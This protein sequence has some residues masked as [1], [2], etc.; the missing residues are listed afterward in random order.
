MSHEI[1]KHAEV[2]GGEKSKLQFIITTLGSKGVILVSKEGNHKHYPA[3]DIDKSLIKSSV[4][5]GDS[6]LGGL[7]Y[8][9]HKG[10][11][12]DKFIEIG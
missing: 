12:M 9:L 11:T 2:L 3:L 7:I 5:S 8:G 1:L 10:L 6:F 4:G